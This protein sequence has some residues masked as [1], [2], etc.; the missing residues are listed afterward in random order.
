MKHTISVLT[1]TGLWDEGYEVIRLIGCLIC[2]Q[3]DG[4]GYSEECDG[5]RKTE[6]IVLDFRNRK[7]EY[8]G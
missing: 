6:K 7:V 5:V 8:N 3:L 1:A 4:D 2:H